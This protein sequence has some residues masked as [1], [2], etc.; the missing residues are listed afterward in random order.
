MVRE[1]T[2]K[3]NIIKN[4]FTTNVLVLILV[5]SYANLGGNSATIIQGH[6]VQ[7]CEEYYSSNFRTAEGG[8]K[9]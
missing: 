5:G 6:W 2:E 3:K 4:I 9:S 8:L 1:R 7:T